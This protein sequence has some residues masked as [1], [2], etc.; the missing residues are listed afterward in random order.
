MKKNK[1][2]LSTLDKP[3]R[4]TLMVVLSGMW[5]I[6]FC[7]GMSSGFWWGDIPFGHGGIAV[8]VLITGLTFMQARSL[9]HSRLSNAEFSLPENH[10][11][12]RSAGDG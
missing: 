2:P 4:L 9:G 3:L 5:T 12:K 10:L 1:N 8:G 7:L 11:T 6:I